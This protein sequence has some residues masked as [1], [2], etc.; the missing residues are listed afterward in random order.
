MRCSGVWDLAVILSL[1][2]FFN[3]FSGLGH[4]KLKRHLS[5]GPPVCHPVPLAFATRLTNAL[6]FVSFISLY[7]LVVGHWSAYQ[8]HRAPVDV[9]EA[10]VADPRIKTDS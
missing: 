1:L 7:A 10:V 2:S 8:A 4:D 6:A 9:V 5:R 3:V